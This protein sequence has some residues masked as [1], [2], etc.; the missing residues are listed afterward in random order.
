MPATLGPLSLGVYRCMGYLARLLVF[1]V[2]HSTF[3][4]QSGGVEGYGSP[5]TLPGLEHFY[6]VASQAADLLGQALGYGLQASLEG[7]PG[8]ETS[9][10]TKTIAH[11]AHLRRRLLEDRRKSSPT[12]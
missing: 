9:L 1:L 4:L 7:A 2:P 3:S 10:L 11:H 6:Q 5:S 12:L 8:G